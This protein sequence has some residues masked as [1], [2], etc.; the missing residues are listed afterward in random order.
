MTVTCLVKMTS[1]FFQ[2]IG[3]PL[4]A[5]LSSLVRDIVCFTPLAL[6]LP[7]L[8]EQKATGNGI[9]GIL[10][11]APVS[12]AVAIVVILV[13]T[14]SFFRSLKKEETGKTV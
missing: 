4:H 14:V 1:V 3:K 2:A 5:I 8:L 13:L 10:Y 7:K 6:L 12:D 9:N 11:A